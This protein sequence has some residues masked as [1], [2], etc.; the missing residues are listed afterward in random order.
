MSGDPE[1]PDA[2]NVVSLPEPNESQL[3]IGIVRGTV[4]ALRPLMDLPDGATLGPAAVVM[5]V[6]TAEGHRYAS[7][8]TAHVLT[9]APVSGYVLKAMLRDVVDSVERSE[10]GT[11]THP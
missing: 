4:D 11:H 1:Q 9:G 7:F 2:S 8:T 5:E 3:I 10:R 6:Q